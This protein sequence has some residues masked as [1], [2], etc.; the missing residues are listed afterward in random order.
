MTIL[1]LRCWIYLIVVNCFYF[2]T[3]LTLRCWIYLIVVNCFYFMTILAL[4]CWIYLIVVFFCDNIATGLL[5]CF[6]RG[7]LLWS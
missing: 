6:N 2:M 4:G 7:I 3:I 5:N 1:T